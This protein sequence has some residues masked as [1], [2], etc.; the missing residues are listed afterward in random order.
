LGGIKLRLKGE[1]PTENTLKNAAYHPNEAQSQAVPAIFW[2][3]HMVKTGISR[4]TL[5]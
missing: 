4:P 3:K 1:I 2:T 5:I